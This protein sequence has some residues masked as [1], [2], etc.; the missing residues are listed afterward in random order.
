[1]RAECSSASPEPNQ[2]RVSHS[3]RE[4]DRAAQQGNPGANGNGNANGS[5]NGAGGGAGTNGTSL[6]SSVGISDEAGVYSAKTADSSFA[7]TFLDGL[8]TFKF[9]DRFPLDK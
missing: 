7:S 2:N 1:M 8:K 9:L 5:A 6:L 3:T 4:R